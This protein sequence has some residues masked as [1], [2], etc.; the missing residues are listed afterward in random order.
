M[1]HTADI[2]PS[3]V[4]VEAPWRERF[5]MLRVKGRDSWSLTITENPRI[6]AYLQVMRNPAL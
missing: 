3:P 1:L 2:E 5:V 6:L 4:I